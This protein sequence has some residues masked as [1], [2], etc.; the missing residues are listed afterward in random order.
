MAHLNVIVPS[1]ID[2]WPYSYP[3][4]P[5]ST[6]TEFAGPD[7][8]ELYER[9]LKYLPQDWIY[10]K[11]DI[12]YSFNSSR[13]RMNKDIE[14]VDQ[15]Y[16]LF[17]GTSYTMGVGIK[18]EDRFSEKISKQLNLDFINFAGPTYSVKIQ[19]ISFFNLLKTNL[20]LPKVLVVE[21][22]PEIGYTFYNNGNFV[23]ANKP[24]L[25]HLQGH[26]TQA[27]VYKT[28]LDTDFFFQEANI[29]RNMLIGTC[30]RLGI[31]MLEVSFNINDRFVTENGI[32]SIDDEYK[33]VDISTELARDV[34][35]HNGNYSAHP[36][37]GIHQLITD[38]LLKL[39]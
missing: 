33:G 22:A 28:L 39:I 29:Y 10:R 6:T 36:G 19:T 31:K 2:Y 37:T 4:N 15:S 34:R 16:I 7:S 17:S 24:F 23:C 20:P 11:T 1:E 12:E 21:N 14:N 30:K 26:D 38:R 18:E 9:N 32:L 8:R 13:L 27:D 3:D 35:I 25:K 5:V